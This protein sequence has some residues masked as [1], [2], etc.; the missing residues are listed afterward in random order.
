M[1][2]W[3]TTMISACAFLGISSTV[4][5]TSCEQDAC[6]DLKCRNGGTC[7]DGFCRCASGYEGT[8]CEYSVAMKFVGHYYGDTKCDSQPSYIDSAYVYI[9]KSPNIIGV[10]RHNYLKDTFFATVNADATSATV[11]TVEDQR[12]VHVT[13]DDTKKLTLK[14]Q[15]TING[16]SRDCTFHGTKG[17]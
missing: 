17:I 2:F 4:L 3:K 12:S 11:T 1:N 5:Y 15:E 8:Q 13:I 6:L 10:V 16:K 7:T 9:E 14:V